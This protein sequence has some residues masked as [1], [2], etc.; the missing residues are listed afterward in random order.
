MIILSTNKGGCVCELFFLVI[1]IS[2]FFVFVLMFVPVS[3]TVQFSFLR[4]AASLSV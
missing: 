1:I 4:G 3:H 2:T